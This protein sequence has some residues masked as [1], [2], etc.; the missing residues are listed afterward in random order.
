MERT[1]RIRAGQDILSALGIGLGIPRGYQGHV[2]ITVQ[3][4]MSEFV[5]SRSSQ[6]VLTHIELRRYLRGHVRRWRAGIRRSIAVQPHIHVPRPDR[7]APDLPRSNAPWT[8]VSRWAAV[9][10]SRWK[11]AVD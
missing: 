1:N 6:V 8:P 5:T 4:P 9:G 7:P 2:L 10:G 3:H 11:K